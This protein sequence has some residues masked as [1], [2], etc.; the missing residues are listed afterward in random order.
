MNQRCLMNTTIDNDIVYR[1][2]CKYA[3]EKQKL[4]E[5]A[6]QI[7][8]SQTSVTDPSTRCVAPCTLQSIRDNMITTC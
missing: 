1:I 8:N 3:D 4:C 6:G 7:L 5:Y 2:L